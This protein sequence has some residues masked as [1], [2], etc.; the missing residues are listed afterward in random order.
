MILGLV[1]ERSISG[2]SYS[3]FRKDVLVLKRVVLLLESHIFKLF[4]VCPGADF[5][6]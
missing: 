3:G 5:L 6:W 2:S 1:R 4:G